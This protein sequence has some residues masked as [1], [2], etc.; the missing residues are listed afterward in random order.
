MSS[1][2]EIAGSSGEV[3]V[4]VWQR[5]ETSDG[6]TWDPPGSSLNTIHLGVYRGLIS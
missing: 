1:G 5:R 2:T 4:R 3:E 6:P